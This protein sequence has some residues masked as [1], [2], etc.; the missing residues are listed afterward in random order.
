MTA[1]QCY[2]GDCAECRI[3]TVIRGDAALIDNSNTFYVDTGEVL[4]A[5]ANNV[6]VLLAALEA[7]SSVAG[8]ALAVRDM[9]TGESDTEMFFAM[10]H[11]ARAH[12]LTEKHVQEQRP[13]VGHA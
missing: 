9:L 13:G 7:L 2:D 8:E 11:R 1:H 3:R 5:V 10:V 4:V 12:W 6:G